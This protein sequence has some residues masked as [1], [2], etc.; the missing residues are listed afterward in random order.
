LLSPAI[1]PEIICLKQIEQKRW[2]PHAGC[3]GKAKRASPK[4]AI[5]DLIARWRE[6]QA[7]AARDGL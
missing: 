7:N 6:S 5:A 2:A 3:G 1:V 4:H